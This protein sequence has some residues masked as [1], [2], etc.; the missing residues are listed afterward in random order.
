MIEPERDWWTLA[1][2]LADL[3]AEVAGIELREQAR[4]RLVEII[5]E[6]LVLLTCWPNQGRPAK[7][8]S[9]LRNR[10]NRMGHH[11]P[12]FYGLPRSTRMLLI[13]TDRR[14]SLLGF[15][16]RPHD[17]TD[18]LR[19]YWRNGLEAFVRQVEAAA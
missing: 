11:A 5:V 4:E 2:Y 7:P 3:A 9:Y 14:P 8:L 6:L 12:W 19:R 15:S 18:G 16:V 1:G 10:R 13:G 17:E